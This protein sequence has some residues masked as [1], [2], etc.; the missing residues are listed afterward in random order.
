MRPH[1]QFLYACL[2]DFLDSLPL[3]HF[4]YSDGS[5]KAPVLCCEFMQYAKY[6]LFRELQK[7]SVNDIVIIRK[8][9]SVGSRKVIVSSKN[10]YFLIQKVLV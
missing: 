6:L 9:L 5:R 8:L 2:A 1:L 4:L 7:Q 3:I 10:I